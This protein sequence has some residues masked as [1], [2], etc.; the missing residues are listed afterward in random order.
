M[1]YPLSHGRTKRRYYTANPQRHVGL[2]DVTSKTNCATSRRCT[3]A[4]IIAEESK[5][6]GKTL[7]GSSFCPTPIP[8]ILQPLIPGG[9]PLR[10]V[11]VSS[12]MITGSFPRSHGRSRLATRSASR[13]SPS[14]RPWQHPP[15]A[16]R[17]TGTR[18]RSGTTA[19]ARP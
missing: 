11:V 16:W 12:S 9:A 18:R 14:T 10:S 8:L 13:A 5:F 6:A 7:Q 17:G 4:S 2:R 19:C 3:A 1:L 15:W